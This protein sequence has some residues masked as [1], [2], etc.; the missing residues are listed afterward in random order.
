MAH[1]ARL[2]ENNMVIDVIVVNNNELLVNGV[3]SEQKGI[4]FCRS[5]YGSN[6]NWAQTSYNSSF[7]GFYAYP[8]CFFSKE[9]NTFYGMRPYPSWNL[10]PDTLYWTP[11]VPRPSSKIE[12]INHYFWNEEK[13]NWEKHKLIHEVNSETE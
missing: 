3:E 8:G 11:P 13:G 9:K 10:N 6:T 7:R 1:F 5:V 2:D 12:E 4:D